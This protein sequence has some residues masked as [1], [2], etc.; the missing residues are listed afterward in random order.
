MVSNITNL[1]A[2]K[3]LQGVSFQ[4]S[5]VKEV[6]D[7]TPPFFRE[8]PRDVALSEGQSFYLAFFM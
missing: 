8:K 1:A 3:N 5:T 4:I 6:I 7:G 2:E